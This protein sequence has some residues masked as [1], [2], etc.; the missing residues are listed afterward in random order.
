MSQYFETVFNVTKHINFNNC[1]LPAGLSAKLAAGVCVHERVVIA[2][3]EATY[4]CSLTP[5]SYYVTC[6]F[7]IIF[8]TELSETEQD[9]IGDLELD[10]NR[11]DE[12]HGYVKYISR[13]AYESL[14]KS[15]W[16]GELF[17]ADD[18]DEAV[19]FGNMSPFCAIVPWNF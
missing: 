12:G 15:G 13:D 2:L 8:K 1:D 11:D 19:E 7:D 16:A 6:G 10:L 5:S 3:G 17:D 14:K 9:I 4:A 18:F